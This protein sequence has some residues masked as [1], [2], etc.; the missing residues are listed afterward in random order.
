MARRVNP[1]NLAQFSE[2]FVVA[3]HC[4]KHLRE[5]KSELSV[6]RA[7]GHRTARK[8]LGRLE[9]LAAQRDNRAYLEQIGSI[10]GMS[11]QRIKKRGRRVKVT[12]MK[13]L[14]NPLRLLLE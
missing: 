7:R 2:R 12:G 11:Q 8:A 1:Q 10:A 6:F 5:R 3:L 4:R 9:A 14:Q 13:F